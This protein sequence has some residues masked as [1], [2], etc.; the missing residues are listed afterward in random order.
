MT[1][2]ADKR[3]KWDDA[4]KPEPDSNRRYG[5]NSE[6]YA[7]A[8]DDDAENAQPLPLL[9]ELLPAKNFPVEALPP[10]M[11]AAVEAISSKIQVGIEMAVQSVLGT[12]AL[13]TQAY[14]DVRMPRALSGRYHCFSIQSRRQE[15]ARPPRTRR[16]SEASKNS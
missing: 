1:G 13:A 2:E 14:A 11:A 12:A 3:D 7:N 10:V 9:P 4:D 16:R 8:P 6:G 5:A 15:S